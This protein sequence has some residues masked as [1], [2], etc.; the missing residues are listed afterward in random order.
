M[1]TN[2]QPKSNS[3]SLKN[4]YDGELV[5]MYMRLTLDL[6]KILSNLS[7]LKQEISKRNINVKNIKEIK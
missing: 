7:L 1:K 6:D 3:P 4:L 5:T 2:Q